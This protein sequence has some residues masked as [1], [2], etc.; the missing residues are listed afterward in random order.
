MIQALL[1]AA[2]LDAAP[3]PDPYQIF[4]RARA[5][6]IH[7]IATVVSRT[8]DYAITFEGTDTIDGHACYHLA[9]QPERDPVRFRIRQAWIDESTYATWQLVDV[10]NF[11][12]T[13]SGAIPWTIHFEDVGG[14][15]YIRE[16]DAGAEMSNTGET[17]SNVAVSFDFTPNPGP[18]LYAQTITVPLLDEP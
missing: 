9:L 7:E 2:T 15:H 13:P 10:R 1:L 14:A 11:R 17:F 18:R 3:T 16:E 12:S 8:R 4:S 5:P 6:T